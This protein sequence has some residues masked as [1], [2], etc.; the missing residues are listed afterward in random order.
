MALTLKTPGVFVEEIS[1][2]PPSIAEVATAIPAFIGYTAIAKNKIDGD[3]NLVP[4][5]IT[6]LLEYETYFGKAANETTITVDVTADGIVVN[7]PSQRSPFIMYYNMQMY[8][9][10]GGGPCYIT[11]VGQFVT[12]ATGGTLATTVQLAALQAG[13]AEVKKQDEPTLLV[14]SDAKFLADSDDFNTI[15]GDALTQ[16]NELQDRF[17]ILDTYTDQ[18]SAITTLRDGLPVEEY[19]LKYGAAYFPYL[20][21]I[22]DYQYEDS[23]VLVTDAQAPS[24]STQVATISNSIK[25]SPELTDLLD[26]LQNLFDVVLPAAT[27]GPLLATAKA[28]ISLNVSRILNY[29]NSVEA[30]MMEVYNVAGEALANPGSATGPQ[31]SAL[32]AAQTALATWANDELTTPIS[33]IEGFL[34]SIPSATDEII[35]AGF[36][37]DIMDALGM[38]G[39]LVPLNE[40]IDTAKSGPSG[41]IF[42]VKDKLT[43]FINIDAYLSSYELNN[44][45]MYNRIKAEIGKVNV[46]LPPSATIAG[47]YARVDANSG[48][49]T[50]PA[51]ASVSYVSGPTQFIDN[52]MQDDMN[53]TAT[54]KSINAIRSFTGRGTL[55][56]GARTLTGNSNE[57]RYVPVRRFFNMV[58]E[59]T[60]KATEQ[61]VFQGNNA[62][63][64]VKIK[65]M[66]E[67]YLTQQWKAGAL[68]GAKPEQ[69][70]YVSVG[71]GETMTAQ[72]IL[73]GKM[74]IEIGMA[75]VR[76]AEFI[77]LQF[78]HKMQEA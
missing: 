46:I 36:V 10:N 47:I 32:T 58:E 40:V 1:K 29:M 76:P 33:Q 2:F 61:F 7:G 3:L 64:W 72:D 75:V 19:K 43:P 63:T 35:T 21:T 67:A 17:T 37:E 6:S 34:A 24:F 9:A 68:T 59:S 8:F 73:E 30:K 15:Y 77:V 55:V 26:Q 38:T 74:I 60:R 70:F 18:A 42:T 27:T 23:D 31:I 57:W 54:G 20:R 50:A 53:V 52:E 56:W 14:F 16:C 44:N 11:S 78:S 12:T 4:T 69:A 22:L 49:W 66:I 45:V 39:V 51:N 65:G 25:T 41:K 71:L 62:N 28:A 13:L 48:V 5:R